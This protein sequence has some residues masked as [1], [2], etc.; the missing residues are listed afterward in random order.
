MKRTTTQSLIRAF[1]ACSMPLLL[2]LGGLN[3]AQAQEAL[4]AQEQQIVRVYLA[5]YGRPPDAGGLAHWTAKVAQSGSLEGIMDAF[6][7]S[8]EFRDRFGGLSNEALVNNLYRQTFGRDAEP[9][10]LQYWTSQLDSGERSLSEIALKILN[11]AKNDDAVVV[12]NRALVAASFVEE[13]D[14]PAEIDAYKGDA[15]ANALAD[16]MATV[17]ADPLSAMQA[18]ERFYDRVEEFIAESS[19]TGDGGDQGGDPDNDPPVDNGQHTEDLIVPEGFAFSSSWVLQ[20]DVDVN[21]YIQE[22]AYLLVCSNFDTVAGEYEIDYGT[23]QLRT[24]L[25]NG[26]HRSDLTMTDTVDDLLV[27]VLPLSAPDEAIYFEWNVEE[28]GANLMIR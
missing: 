17:T 4:S 2:A 25:I 22:A 9:G 13:L 24:P 11:G 27:V 19:S 28:E 21:S 1:I 26:A 10:G 23:C 14:T 20:I 15:A 12:T 16:L 18:I 7:N 8:P 5:Y 6:G 3:G